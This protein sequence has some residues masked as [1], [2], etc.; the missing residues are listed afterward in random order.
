MKPV[1]IGIIGCG[2]ISSAYLKAMASFPILNI[3][4]LA[5]LNEDLARRKGAEF[6]IPATNVTA[7]LADPDIEII[8]NLT[9]PKAHVAVG[10]QALNAGKHTYSEKP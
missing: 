10:L 4:G 8:V 9:V 1:G 7:L 2:N 5:D 3:V 6:N